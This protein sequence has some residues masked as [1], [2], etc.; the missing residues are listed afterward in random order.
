MIK[1][2]IKNPVETDLFFATETL[3]MHCVL[4]Q[5]TEIIL[6]MILV[7]PSVKHL[8]CKVCKVILVNDQFGLCVSE[9]LKALK[10]NWQT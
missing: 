6:A 10:Q 7:F 3:H 9:A 1:L 4:K 5:K 8:S 2:S